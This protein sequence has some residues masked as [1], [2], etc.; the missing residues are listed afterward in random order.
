[1]SKA[2]IDAADK[3]VDPV[4][5]LPPKEPLRY[6]TPDKAAAGMLRYF[7]TAMPNVERALGT[8]DDTVLRATGHPPHPPPRATVFTATETGMTR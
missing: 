8:E 6:G 7:L 5:P 2:L 3:G 4:L 1:M